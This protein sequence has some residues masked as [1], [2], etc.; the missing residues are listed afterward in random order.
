MSTV[1][2]RAETIERGDAESRG[3]ISVGATADGAFTQGQIHLLCECLGAGEERF[4]HFALERRT[5]KAAGD[6]KLRTMLKRPQSVQAAFETAH[7][8]TAKRTQIEHSAGAL[9]DDGDARAA[10]D[11]AGVA[12]DAAARIIPSFDARELP[13]QFVNGVD[14]F[15]WRQP[16]V[17]RSAMH[18][19]FGLTYSLSRCLQQLARTPRML[20]DAHQ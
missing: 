19:Q 20:K 6:F 14:A 16:G 13:R 10:F 15:L 17:R 9:G 7:V 18:H 2:D 1:A 11:D 5:A 12:G 3:V 4:A 8:G